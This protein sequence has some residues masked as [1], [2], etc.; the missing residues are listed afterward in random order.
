MAKL[1]QNWAK[2]NI[3]CKKWL[4]LASCFVFY[5]MLTVVCFWFFLQHQICSMLSNWLIYI[6]WTRKGKSA[7]CWSVNSLESPQWLTFGATQLWT[8]ATSAALSGRRNWNECFATASFAVELYDAVKRVA[9]AGLLRTHHTVQVR[10]VKRKKKNRQNHV[11][12]HRLLRT[13]VLLPA[14]E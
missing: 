13:A 6:C 1:A 2:K 7:Q 3:E 8:I 11:L 9:T 14:F 5:Y 4:K 10:L 12:L